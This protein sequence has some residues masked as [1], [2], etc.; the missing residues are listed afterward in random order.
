VKIEHFFDKDTFT[1]TYVVS[2]GSDAVIID[3]VLDYEPI[4]SKATTANAQ[5]VADFVAKNSFRVHWVLETHAH[6]DHMTASEW[7]A[8]KTGAKLGIGSGITI[9]QSMFKNIYALEALKTDGSQFDRLFKD[10]ET[11][12][13][14]ALKLKVM[15]TP[16]HTP[17]CVTYLTDAAA[18]AFVGDAIFIEDYGCGRCDF[19]GGDASALYTSIHE[20]IYALP[21]D[22]LLFPAH[23]YLP[24][25]RPLRTNTSVELSRSENVQIKS[26]TTREAFVK[27]RHDRDKTL[28]TPRLLWPS[29]QVN[30]DGGRVPKFLKIP[31]TS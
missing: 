7:L 9:V 5:H 30:I 1:L 29:V 3:P 4:A 27:F 12:D 2:E 15:A 20:K 22:T 31:V 11:V 6:A 25:G 16:G 23:D 28:S 17:G 21:P 10:G 26:D 24:H 19:P 14:G 18:A 8:K 13:A